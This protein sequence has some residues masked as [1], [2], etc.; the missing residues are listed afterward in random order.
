MV[1]LDRLLTWSNP[2]ERKSDPYKKRSPTVVRIVER[3]GG[4]CCCK[5]TL[6]C[7]NLQIFSIENCISCMGFNVK[8]SNFHVFS[9]QNL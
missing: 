8:S 9:P 5:N 7:R 2:I 6:F 1:Q 4:I 3:R